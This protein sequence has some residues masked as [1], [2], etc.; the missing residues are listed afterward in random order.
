MLKIVAIA[1]SVMPVH[2]SPAAVAIFIERHR[3]GD[4]GGPILLLQHREHDADLDE[5][6]LFIKI[7]VIR[8]GI[9]WISVQVGFSVVMKEEV[10]DEARVAYTTMLVHA[11]SG[12]YGRLRVSVLQ[13][14]VVHTMLTRTM[15]TL[16]IANTDCRHHDFCPKNNLTMVAVL[17]LQSETCNE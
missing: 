9:P 7:S 5:A 4:P 8:G 2:I 6:R 17:A 1:A 13:L 14:S 10:P 16:H 11:P 3:T 15:R 12:L